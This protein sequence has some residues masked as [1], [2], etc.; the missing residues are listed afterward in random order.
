VRDLRDKI[1]K[2]GLPEGAKKEA[3]KE[4]GRLEM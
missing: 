4:L 2:A 3:E 1:E